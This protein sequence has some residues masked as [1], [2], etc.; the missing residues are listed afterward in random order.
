LINI[1]SDVAYIIGPVHFCYFFA[2]DA[3]QIGSNL[4]KLR[5]HKISSKN[6]YMEPKNEK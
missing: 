6:V 2:D 3:E 5:P 4:N 1:L